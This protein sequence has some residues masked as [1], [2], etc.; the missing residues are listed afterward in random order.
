MM[1]VVC[2][3]ND[4]KGMTKSESVELKCDSILR[5]NIDLEGKI[6]SS[7]QIVCPKNCAE[8][9]EFRVFGYLKYSDLSSICRA[10]LQ[11]GLITDDKGGELLIGIEDDMH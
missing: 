10:A 4:A 11:V 3:T 8:K 1:G 6:G 7:Y 5:S 9:H 2:S